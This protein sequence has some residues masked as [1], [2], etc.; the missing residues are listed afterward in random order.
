VIRQPD[1]RS[2]DERTRPKLVAARF[3]ARPN[4]FVVVAALSSGRRVEAHLADPG[5]LKELLL[6]GAQLRLRPALRGSARKTRFSVSLVR[7]SDAGRP[8]VSVNSALANRLAEELLVRGKLRGVGRGWSVRSEVPRGNSR[9]DFRLD[10]FS[11]PPLWVEVKSVTLVVDG[12][13]RFP[14]APT[15]R[16]RR[17]LEELTE[18]TTAG[19]RALVLFVVQREDAHSVVPHRTIDPRF[20]AALA[21]AKRAGVML[22]AARFG[23]D[24]DGRATYLG[25][26]PVRA[27]G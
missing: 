8:W 2:T 24:A 21:R 4:R 16:G 26:L 23:L 27:A 18:L 11:R 6:P 22:R 25:A 9:F 7:S 13:A 20:A 1:Q 19:E 17:H 10:Q 5:R 14:D 15:A 12:V 3:V